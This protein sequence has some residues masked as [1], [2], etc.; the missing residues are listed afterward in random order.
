[1][2]QKSVYVQH[3]G[4][5]EANNTEIKNANNRQ[6]IHEGVSVHHFTSVIQAQTLL[7]R[8]FLENFFYL[9]SVGAVEV[10]VTE[11]KG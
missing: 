1:M 3:T 9:Q 2:R 7:P 5:E 4:H 8:N 11:I 10:E 6:R